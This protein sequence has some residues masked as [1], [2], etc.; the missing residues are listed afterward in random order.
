MKE[1]TSFDNSILKLARKLQTKSGRVKNGMFIAE[2]KRIVD[3]AVSSGAVRYV[4]TCGEDIGFENTYRVSEKLYARISDTVSPQGIMAVC[5]IKNAD[6]DFDR[7]KNIVICDGI[8]DPG[9]LGT[10][11]RTAECA[12]FG[13]VLLINNCA[14]AF[15]P[16]TVRSTMGSIFRIP[17][18]EYSIPEVLK[19][20]GYRFAVTMLDGAR[21]IFKTDFSGKIALAV[22]SEAFGVCDELKKHAVLPVKI[23]MCGQAESINAAV[24]AGIAMYAIKNYSE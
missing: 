9:N 13:A 2:G 17:V 19:L 24:A 5:D 15:N 1:I 4:I 22:G 7:I 18:A 23:P 11:I 12:G 16:K 3:D 8:K 21:D 6:I 20:D 10:I 14:D